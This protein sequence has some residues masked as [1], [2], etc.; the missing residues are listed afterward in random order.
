M[1]TSQSASSK[2]IKCLWDIGCIASIIGIWP[3]YIEPNL[4][5]ST[6]VSLPIEGLPS[7]LQG[8][9]IA[10]F[11]DLHLGPSLPDRTLERLYRKISKWQPDII[12]FTGDFICY[13]DLSEPERLKQFLK[14]FSAPLGCYAIYGNHDYSSYVGVNAQGDYDIMDSIPGEIGR[15]L[16][17][18]VNKQHVSGNMSPRLA[19]VRPHEELAS[20]LAATPFQLLENTTIQL[21]V[22][23]AKLN[24]T[25][26]GEYMAHRFQPQTAYINYD[27]SAP[28]ITLAHNPDCLPHLKEF[29]GDVILCGH[30]HG[31]QV[32]VP[33][34]RG[35]FVVMENPQYCRGTF[36]LNEKWV[37]INRGIGGSFRFRF[38]AIPEISFITLEKVT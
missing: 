34:I 4:L 26:L 13:A 15:G 14:K 36:R 2:A 10:Q 5:C 23:N 32:N 29:P 1:T 31:G 8:L 27:A 18:V 12:V 30:V 9:K 22:K 25:G 11:S 17:R 7:G 16:N 24:L 37:H 6:L 21:S 19:T 33:W 38:A 3:R 35:R 20:L 28:G